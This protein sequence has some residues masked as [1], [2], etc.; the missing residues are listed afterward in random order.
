MTYMVI[1]SCISFLL[2]AKPAGYKIEVLTREYPFYETASPALITNS[3]NP[4]MPWISNM[5]NGIYPYFGSPLQ[6]PEIT[7]VRVALGASR[8][9]TQ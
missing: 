7:D 8:T 6:T 5:S 9:I 4:V 2:H 1:G 3:E